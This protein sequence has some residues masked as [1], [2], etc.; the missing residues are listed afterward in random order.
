[1]IIEKENNWIKFRFTDVDYKTK[2]AEIKIFIKAIKLN[3]P[4]KG[5]RYFGNQKIWYIS[6]LFKNTFNE[7]YAKYIDKSQIKII[8]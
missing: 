7:L 3:I 5:R 1:M 4:P 6:S 8:E 2:H